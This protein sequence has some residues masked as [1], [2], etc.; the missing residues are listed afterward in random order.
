MKRVL[1][2]AAVAGVAVFLVVVLCRPSSRIEVTNGG[3]DVIEVKRGDSA[4]TTRLGQNGTGYF[5]TDSRL[6]IGDAKISVGERLEVA[7]T[8]SDVLQVAYEDAAGSKRT[9]LLAEA[10]TG[11]FSKEGPIEIGDVSVRVGKAP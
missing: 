1:F 8:G 9:M 11:Y 6:Q 7:N 5:D 4:W 2:V 10:G 3:A